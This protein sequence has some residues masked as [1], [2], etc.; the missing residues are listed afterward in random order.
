MNIIQKETTVSCAKKDLLT[1]LGCLEQQLMQTNVKV[2]SVNVDM[3]FTLI[4]L[5]TECMCN[6]HANNCE[7]NMNESTAICLNCM[8]NTAGDNCELC[9]PGF[10][11]DRA[12]LLNDPAICTCKSQ[13]II[14]ACHSMLSNSVSIICSQFL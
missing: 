2:Y 4:I 3:D 14:H 1:A 9:Q 8:D 10:F 12:L 7:Y 13:C 6:G 11:Q 5:C